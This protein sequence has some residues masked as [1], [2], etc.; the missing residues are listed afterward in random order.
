MYYMGSYSKE[1]ILSIPLR[2]KRLSAKDLFTTHFKTFNSF[3]DE[4]ESGSR[5]GEMGTLYT[6]NSFEDETKF[7]IPHDVTRPT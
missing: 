4:T 3:E 6:F 7:F 2:M 1:Q 5:R